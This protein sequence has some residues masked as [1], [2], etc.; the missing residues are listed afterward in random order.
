MQAGPDQRSRGQHRAGAVSATG[1]RKTPLRWLPWVA[2]L[3]LA[4]LVAGAA[5]I[6]TNVSDENDEPGIE[7]RDDEVPRRGRARLG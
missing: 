6:V 1:A 2:L 3:L 4:L 5:L 7:L